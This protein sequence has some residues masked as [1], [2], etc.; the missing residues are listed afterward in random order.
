MTPGILGAW[1]L[2]IASVAAAV[3]L[4][5]VVTGVAIAFVVDLVEDTREWLHRT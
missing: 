3:W 1:A 2:S 4:C 5:I